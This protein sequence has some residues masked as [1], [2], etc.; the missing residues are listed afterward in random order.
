LITAN[1]RKLKQFRTSWH[2]HASKPASK[3]SAKRPLALFTPLSAGYDC[4][5]ASSS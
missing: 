5:N 3:T 1:R 4:F 2:Q